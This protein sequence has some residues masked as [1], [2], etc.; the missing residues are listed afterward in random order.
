MLIRAFSVIRK[1]QIDHHAV[2][3]YA[4]F[5]LVELQVII[6]HVIHGL[7]YGAFKAVPIGVV[8][9]KVA[10]HAFAV[11]F[12]YKPAVKLRVAC[13]KLICAV[14]KRKHCAG[15]AHGRIKRIGAGKIAYEICFIFPRYAKI[16]RRFVRG[17]GCYKQSR[18][19]YIHVRFGEI[20]NVYSGNAA[21]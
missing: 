19:I 14:Y 9:P 13:V 10:Q 18:L 3:F 8:I 2:A 6:V 7:F 5:L 17:G 16:M 1:Q 11:I 12:A 4:V 20:R 21:V 15:I